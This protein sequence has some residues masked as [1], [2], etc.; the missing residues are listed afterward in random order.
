M[1]ALI[2]SYSPC[3]MATLVAST[4]IPADLTAFTSTVGDA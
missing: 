4:G 2:Q 3:L 1:H